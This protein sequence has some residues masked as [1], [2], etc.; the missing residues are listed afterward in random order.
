MAIEAS[1]RYRRMASQGKTN[2]DGKSGPA[3]GTELMAT[4]T[5]EAGPGRW[6][7]ET[8]A[9]PEDWVA[10]VRMRGG[11]APSA[12]PKAYWVFD[13]DEKRRRAY[14][15]DSD[16]GRLPISD[17][18]RPRYASALAD[19]LR[20]LSEEESVPRTQLA[21]S[22]SEVKGMINRCLRKD[23]W[24]WFSAYEV[25]GKPDRGWMRW[26]VDTLDRLRR[27]LRDA[28]ETAVAAACSKLREIGATERFRVSLE[29]VLASTP[30]LPDVRT[31][32]RQREDLAAVRESPERAAGRSAS[33]ATRRKLGR[34]N[35]DHHEVLT[36]L[37]SYLT[38][39]GH[40]IEEGK[41]VDAFCHLRTGP[42]IFEVKSVSPDNELSQCRKALSQLYEY[43]FRHG[44]EEASLWLVLS[45]EPEA[46]PWLVEYLRE[47]R[48]VRLLWLDGEVL[49]GPDLPLLIES[50]SEALRRTDAGA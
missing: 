20:L 3:L 11:S 7:A 30:K 26:T 41:H 1:R 18:M 17:R 33:E 29:A 6:R 36:T 49:T 27:A 48:G 43:R 16:F 21:S 13:V 42:A 46:E 47:D 25:L 39:H 32:S 35:A 44:L 31:P 15:S 37:T 28:D 23:Q 40:E 19:V 12:E 8:D 22:V 45:K 24:D 10:I 9:L 14:L 50:G 2:M 4:V 38:S 34:A 5:E